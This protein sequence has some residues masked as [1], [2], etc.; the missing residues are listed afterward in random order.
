MPYTALPPS[1]FWRSCRDDPHFL[2]GDLY[3]PKFELKPGMKIATAG[4]CFAQNIGR[5]LRASDLQL[6]DTEPAPTMMPEQ[7]ATRFGYGLFS[8]RYGNIYTARQLLQ[9]LRD[10][11]LQTLHRSAMWQTDGRWFDGLRPNVEPEGLDTLEAVQSLR[12]AHLG[13]VSEIF[14]TADIFIFTLG[15][16]EAWHDI[17]TGV[18]FPTAPGTIAGQYKPD[19]HAFMNFSFADCLEDLAAAIAEMRKMRPGLK[20]ILTVSPVPLT[21]TASGEHVLQATTYSKAV[22]RAVAGEMAESDPSIDYFPSYE[23]ITGTPFGNAFYQPNLRNV[24]PTGVDLVMS[25]FFSA[26]PPLTSP[27]KPPSRTFY[28]TEGVENA[29]PEI[30][31]E[32]LLEAFAPKPGMS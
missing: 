2:L 5:Y 11:Q 6:I 32:A 1:A 23:I 10:A 7:T 31:E 17:E 8:A 30:C 24:S 12:K 22:L 4:S 26:H 20:V 18:V 29:V 25:T 9:L 14:Q 28:Q 16:T 19:R 21:A 15:L 3:R 13:Q 27:D